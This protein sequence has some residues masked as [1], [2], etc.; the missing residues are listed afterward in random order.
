MATVE[1][2]LVDHLSRYCQRCRNRRQALAAVSEAEVYAEPL[3]TK[4]RRQHTFRLDEYLEFAEAQDRERW[5]VDVAEQKVS[6][7]GSGQ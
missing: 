7:V 4:A 5:R 2:V 6:S 1:S 3:N